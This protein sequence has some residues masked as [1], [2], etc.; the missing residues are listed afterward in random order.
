MELAS[1]FLDEMRDLFLKGVGVL[2]QLY[3]SQYV[4]FVVR[5]FECSS[6]SQ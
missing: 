1:T 5:P 2:C 3:G 6:A 4:R